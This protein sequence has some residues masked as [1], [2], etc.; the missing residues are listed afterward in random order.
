[1]SATV[2]NARHAVV[3]LLGAMICTAML[4]SASAPAVVLV[5]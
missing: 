3:A 4:V 1:M 2:A 5:A